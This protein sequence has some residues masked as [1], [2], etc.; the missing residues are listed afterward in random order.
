MSFHEAMCDYLMG[1]TLEDEHVIREIEAKYP[2]FRER[3]NRYRNSWDVYRH[4]DSDIL[5]LS[6]LREEH[7][8]SEIVEDHRIEKF[9]KLVQRADSKK[10][11]WAD[12]D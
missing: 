3:L 4:N 5:L 7:A 1:P 12:E 9:R 10:F 2:G 11:Q 6:M 8:I